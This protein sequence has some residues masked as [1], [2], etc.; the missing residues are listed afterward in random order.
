MQTHDAIWT[1]QIHGWQ[2]GRTRE[3]DYSCSLNM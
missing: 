1:V 2:N 3:A